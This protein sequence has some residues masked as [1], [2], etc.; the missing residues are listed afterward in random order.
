MTGTNSTGTYINGNNLC[1]E[2]LSKRIDQYLNPKQTSNS[3]RI[4]S[5]D[6]KRQ[7]PRDSSTRKSFWDKLFSFIS[8]FSIRPKRKPKHKKMRMKTPKK[9]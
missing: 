4:K 7:Q 5:H 8:S 9:P 3:T 1:G 2:D 6:L